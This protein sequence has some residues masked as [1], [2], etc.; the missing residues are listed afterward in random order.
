MF[1]LIIFDTFL[2]APTSSMIPENEA[3]CPPRSP[4][5]RI[6]VSPQGAARGR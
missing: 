5:H 3:G 2:L 4:A 6:G 1:A